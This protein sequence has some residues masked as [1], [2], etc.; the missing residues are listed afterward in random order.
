M[1]SKSITED[2][3]EEMVDDVS[4][5]TVES[6][7]SPE[8]LDMNKLAALKAKLQSKKAEQNMSGLKA[9]RERSIVFGI[10][11][12]GQAGCI[13]GDSNLYVSKYG[14]IS[15]KELFDLKLNTSSLENIAVQSNSDI[16]IKL[17]EELYTVSIDPET[18]AMKKGKIL[19]VWKNKKRSKNTIKLSNGTQLI[20]SKTHPSLV[21]R[22]N[23]RRKAF[24]SSL[25]DSTPLHVGDKLFD[26]R[27]E[28]LDFISNN[29]FVRDILITPE[30]G[31][32]LGVFAGDG[33]DKLH[34]NSISFSSSDDKLTE[35]IVAVCSTLP[36]TSI[37][38]NERPGCKQVEVFGL[39]FKLFIES[40]FEYIN[41]STSGGIGHKTYDIKIPSCISAAH[42][43]VRSAFLS[44]LIDSD[45]T[46]S[47][48]WCE[49]SISTTSKKMSSQLGCLIS[50]LG[51]RSSLEKCT[52]D[53]Q[54]EKD[55]FRVRLNGKFNFG[56]FMEDILKNI[57]STM[58]HSRLSGHLNRDQ[59]SFASSTALID[60]ND[61]E[62]ILIKD[63]GFKNPNNFYDKT[64]ISLKNWANGSR[65]LSIPKF[66]EAISNLTKSNQLNYLSN[67][68]SNLIEI[69]EISSDDD[70]DCEFYDLTVETYENYVAGENGLLFTHNSRIAE[71]FYRQGYDAVAINTAMQDLKFIDLPDANKLLLEGTLGGAAKEIE[72]GKQAAETHRDS[73]VELIDIK[74]ASSQL[75]ILCLSL[76]GGSGAGS[77][78]T[79]VDILSATGKPLVVITVLPMDTEDAQTKHNALETLSKLA[80]LTQTKK[81]N[82]L[83]VVDNAK[84]EAIYQHVAQNEFFGI[85]NKAIVDPIDAF[86]TLS[87][88]ASS[89][90]GLDPMEFG[91]LFIDGEGLTVF[92]ELVIDNYAEETSLAEAVVNNLDSNLLAG[93][94]DLKQSKYV[95]V[96][97]AANAE[98]WK[99]IPASHVNYAMA[100]INEQ[101]GHPNAVFKGSY[102]VDDIKEN[103]VKIYSMFSGLG[104]PD[105]RVAQLK[106]DAQTHM[107]N[108]K[109]KNDQRN[110]TLALDTGTNDTVSAV[111][112]IKEQIA[113]K[114]SA[115]G[116]LTKNVV[117]DR[118]K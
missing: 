118:R 6:L 92:G 67:I 28:K 80:R 35:N 42:A 26:T 41:Q 85:A 113:A 4:S 98:V 69:D 89:V 76:G 87:S 34:G 110:L 50:S 73:I 22:P 48:D 93:G 60:F 54:N 109:G 47:S 75:N 53:L 57:K 106:K 5:A 51:G 78:E 91:K 100:I 68:V 74:L 7:P 102:T 16:C 63:G 108:A 101:C 43:D 79:L 29:T 56:T 8:A 10:V 19:A 65:E 40:C 12:S 72:I 36:H 62:H 1:A 2:L 111:Q 107:Q 96:I 9:K 18:G 82:N 11:G 104:L 21:F 45:G 81:V 39:Q 61:I 15:I 17:D 38:V 52:N 115:F 64:G 77:C 55:I 116:K 83:I 23:S 86:N 90:K 112:K 97:F 70:I 95:G 71:E 37:S 32:M 117:V 59:K 46:V 103:V 30:I 13:G 25:S 114:S 14:L 66:I 99:S 31:W 27:Q 58:K 24:F 3:K 20:C 33:H 105:S 94:F 44:G 88:L 84:I 49:A